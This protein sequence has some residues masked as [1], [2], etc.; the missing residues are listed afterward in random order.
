MF[1][2]KRGSSKLAYLF[3]FMIS[4][5]VFSGGAS[6]VE[7]EGTPWENISYYV[8]NQTSASVYNLSQYITYSESETPISYLVLQNTS[9]ASNIHGEK[10]PSFFYWISLNESSGILSFNSTRDNRTGSYNI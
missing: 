10:D 1:K 6:A 7:W 3:I 4:L 8:E 9:I 5:I 2:G